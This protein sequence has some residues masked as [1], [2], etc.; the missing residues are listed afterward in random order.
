MTHT[1]VDSFRHCLPNSLACSTLFNTF[2]GKT[3]TGGAGCPTHPGVISF[4]YFSLGKQRKV[5]RPWV[6]KHTFN[7]LAL[8]ATYQIPLTQ[9]LPWRGLLGRLVNLIQLPM[10]LLKLL[11]RPARTRII[12]AY[13]TAF[14]YERLGWCG[15][16]FLE[17]GVRD[18]ILA[19]SRRFGMFIV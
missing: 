11:P 8:A 17:R 15:R 6:R 18:V 3:V 1:G 4:G 2:I 19:Q 14:P 5:S 13:F 9:L 10:T 7:K 12:T 16:F